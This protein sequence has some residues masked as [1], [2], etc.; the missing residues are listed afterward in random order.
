MN[1]A[2]DPWVGAGEPQPRVTVASL[3]ERR[4]DLLMVRRAEGPSPGEW[5]VPATVI[6]PLETMAEA[7]VRALAQQT[8]YDT[9]LCGP[10]LGWTELIDDG[11]GTHQIVMFFQA[12]LLDEEPGARATALEVRWIPTWD[13][14]ELRLVDGLAEFL[15]DQGLID[16]MI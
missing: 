3:V 13:V 1:S 15:A 2:P 10:F 11:D 7:A 4:G 8:G 16:T 5:S 6:E 12:V 9:G 14:P